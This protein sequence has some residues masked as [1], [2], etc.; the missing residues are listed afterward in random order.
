[1][2]RDTHAAAAVV[3]SPRCPSSRPPYSEDPLRAVFDYVRAVG[4]AGE[5]EKF[6]LVTRWPRTVIEAPD[7]GGG[8]VEGSAGAGA[9]G[10]G[11]VA[12]GISSEMTVS[13]SGL[14]PSDT[15]FVERIVE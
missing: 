1:M 8:D 7:A 4:G 15:F 3:A 2:K 9:G 5:G 10:G 12:D 11:G 6:R 13:A 14:Q